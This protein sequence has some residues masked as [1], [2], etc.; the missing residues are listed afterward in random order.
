MGKACKR[1]KH[2]LIQDPKYTIIIPTKNSLEYLKDSI[3]SVISQDFNNYELIV[4][5]NCSGDGTYEYVQSIKK[6]NIRL[7]KTPKVLEMSDHYEWALGF[8]RGDWIVILG[9]DDGV[10]P[11]FFTLLE[12]LTKIAKSKGLNV[13]N[14]VRSYF[15]WTGCQDIYGD[16]AVS[17]SARAVYQ[18]KSAKWA[19]LQ[20]TIGNK[21]YIDLPQMYTTS[22]VH[23]TVIEKV[24][25]KH[26]G[27]FYCINPPDANGAANICL[28]ENK[29]LESLI[30]ISWVG[31]SPKSISVQFAQNKKDYIN[32]AKREIYRAIER[33]PSMAGKFYDKNWNVTI[34]NNFKLFLFASLLATGH[35]Q[36]AFQK[37]VYNSKLFKTL[38]FS[39]LYHDI[40]Y[41]QSKQPD[42]KQQAYLEELVKIN[43][44]KFK[45]VLLY[46]KTI[47]RLVRKMFNL[48][49][50]VNR[51]FTRYYHVP[52]MQL[53]KTYPL[54]PVPRLMDAYN[55]VK[56]LDEQSN[57]IEQYISEN[58]R[59]KKC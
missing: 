37:K 33:W 42:D 25:K 4:S 34:V 58:D 31:S 29:Y 27:A 47:F 38:V 20:A 17:Y 14:S 1:R 49:E 48:A 44:V 16:C 24:R 43:N 18:I 10:M 9:T 52:V 41:S 51:K 5:D 53:Y 46:H 39:N 2:L 21:Y 54:E 12:H 11:Y 35:L 23:K 30:P 50:R 40:K 6:S 55:W 3:S 15:F 32:N 57:F 22:I 7:E 45:S 59:K 56:E 13:I 19:I 28:I 36:S 26:N 8:A